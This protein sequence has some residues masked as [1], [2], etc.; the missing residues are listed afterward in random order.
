MANKKTPRARRAKQTKR[1]SARPRTSRSYVRKRIEIYGILL[2]M[3][4]ILLFISVFVPSSAGLVNESVNNFLSHIFG[5]GKYLIPILLLIW[6]ASFFIKR[7][8]YLPSRFGWGFFL[9]FFSILGIFSND[10]NHN[11]I[12][13]DVLASMRGGITGAWIFHG[14]SRLFGTA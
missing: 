2:V 11:D 10:L 9:L 6:G 14:L 12:F 8:R 3:F 13:D 1:N 5:V 7:I 4:S